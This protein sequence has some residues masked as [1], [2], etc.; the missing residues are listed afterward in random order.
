MAAKS[1][2]QTGSNVAHILQQVLFGGSLRSWLI[3]IGVTTGV[4]LCMVVIQFGLLEPLIANDNYRWTLS[5]LLTV[6][7]LIFLLVAV[8][9]YSYTGG[10]LVD[11]C[12]LPLIPAFVSSLTFVSI[13]GVGGPVPVWR[14]PFS[15]DFGWYL[16]MAVEATLLYGI[17]LGIAGFLIGTAVQAF[18]RI[19][20]S[21]PQ[22]GRAK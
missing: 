12:S 11:C 4:S 2:D 19:R 15:R 8:T 13:V 3:A 17:G 6:L 7:F 14:W 21:R 22:T 1:G 9:A 10:G 18:G 20:P 16:T 5:G